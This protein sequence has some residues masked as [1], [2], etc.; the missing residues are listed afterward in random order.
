LLTL[1]AHL[2]QVFAKIIPANSPIARQSSTVSIKHNAILLLSPRFRP[3]A[4]EDQRS[5]KLL[6]RRRVLNEQQ[7]TLKVNPAATS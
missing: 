6:R 2:T 3:A 7:V 4:N 5:H 1:I